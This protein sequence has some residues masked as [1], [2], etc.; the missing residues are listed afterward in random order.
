MKIICA[1]CGKD[2]GEKDGKGVKGISH[3]VCDK[4]LSELEAKAENSNVKNKNAPR[5]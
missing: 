5:Q 2:L 1:W 4:C 3:G